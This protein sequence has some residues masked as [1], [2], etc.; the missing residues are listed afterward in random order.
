VLCAIKSAA[1]IFEAVGGAAMKMRA[2]LKTFAM[3]FLES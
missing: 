3:P 1:V 2:S